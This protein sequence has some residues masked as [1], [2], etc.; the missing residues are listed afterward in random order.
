M[1]IRKIEQED[2]RRVHVPATATATTA[3]EKE[4]QV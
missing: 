2:D 4:S 1:K 3:R